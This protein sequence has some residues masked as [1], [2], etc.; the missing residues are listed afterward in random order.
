MGQRNTIYIY[1][2]ASEQSAMFLHKVMVYHDIGSFYMFYIIG[3]LS[4]EPN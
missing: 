1:I 3:L 4:W 2:L